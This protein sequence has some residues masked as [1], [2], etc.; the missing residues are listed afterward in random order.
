[1]HANMFGLGQLVSGELIVVDLVCIAAR[2][3]FRMLLECPVPILVL[4]IEP[5]Y[6]DSCKNYHHYRITYL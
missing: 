6:I 2:F 4:W 1:M 5:I 3:E